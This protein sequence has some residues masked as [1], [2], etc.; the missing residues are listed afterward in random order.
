MTVSA[1]GTSGFQ[2]SNLII[3]ALNYTQAVKWSIDATATPQELDFGVL[4]NQNQ[5]SFTPQAVKINNTQ[6]TEACV[7]TVLETGDQVT[8]PAGALGTRQITG[9]T[10]AQISVTGSGA[11]DI[12][13]FDWPAFP[14]SEGYV[15]IANLP[16][17]V[18]ITGQP[19]DMSGSS[20]ATGGV[21]YEVDNVPRPLVA[22]AGDLV[23]AA[24]ATA[25]TFTVATSSNIRKI[26]LGL[27]EDVI[28]TTA[29]D[30]TITL[31]NAAGTILWVGHV[32]VPA[33]ALVG[34]GT[35]ADFVID[36]GDCAIASDTPLTFT[37]SAAPLGGTVYANVYCD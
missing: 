1:S 37:L 13:F 9:I 5:Q 7:L 4:A 15:Q 27:T 10:N 2:T 19:V 34:A 32:Y 24:G 31:K 28:Q 21:S 22:T 16:L 12:F 3:P 6:G 33:A 17:P 20:Q 18:Q 35:L 36:F 23:G 14:D 11:V 25:V 30:M 26:L 29:G 8:I